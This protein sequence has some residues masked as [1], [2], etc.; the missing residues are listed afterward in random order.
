MHRPGCYTRGEPT[1]RAPQFI[2]KGRACMNAS[3]PV[4]WELLLK[5]SPG[6]EGCSRAE[7]AKQLY[8]TP[9]DRGEK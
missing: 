6:C 7:R 9:E 5:A 4:W 1:P 3:S 2:D 8:W